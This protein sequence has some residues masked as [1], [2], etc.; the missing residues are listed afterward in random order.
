MRKGIHYWALPG[1]LCFEEKL[2]LAKQA[3]FEG[4]E[5]TILQDGYL[6]PGSND[7]ELCEIR[8]K[9]E[10]AGLELIDV[11]STLNWH[12]SLTSDKTEIRAM[13]KDHL[14]LQIDIAEKLGA[15]AILALPG[16]V[17]LDFSSGDLFSD[18]GNRRYNPASEVIDYDTAY[19]R[20]L[21]AF[22][23]LSP[24]ARQHGVAICIEN[25]WNRFLLSPL[26][27]RDFI[28]AL[29]SD[30]VG[31]YFDVG[32]VMLTGY[33]EQWIKILG[34]RIKRVHFKDFLRG[35]ARVSGFV[36]LL[37]GDVDFVKVTEALQGIGYKGWVTAE[38]NAS[39]QFPEHTAYACSDALDRILRNK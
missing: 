23:E 35:T 8:K 38:T 28:D 25:I 18:S 20:S 36:E 10:E 2:H 24:Y 12:Y 16:F 9:I 37:A 29:D 33:P 27:M 19:V 3:G 6:R 5:L 39:R 21:E 31:A 22:R 14:R 7:K 11:A 1:H 13:A 4:I 32:N 30:W 15:D 26:E 34:R 17:G